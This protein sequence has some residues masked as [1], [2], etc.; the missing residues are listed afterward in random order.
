MKPSADRAA[1]TNY[2][3]KLW[4]SAFV[5]QVAEVIVSKWRELLICAAAIVAIV[6]RIIERNGGV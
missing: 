1:A 5:Q 3:S 4:R 2:A 6:L